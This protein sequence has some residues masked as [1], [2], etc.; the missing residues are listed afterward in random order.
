[1]Q[2]DNRRFYALIHYVHISIFTFPVLQRRLFMMRRLC[3]AVRLLSLFVLLLLCL[4]GCTKEDTQEETPVSLT[5]LQYELENQTID[6]S[7]MWFFD[8]LENKTGVHVD[9]EDVK[10]VD[11]KTRISLMFASNSYKDLILRGSLDT[12]EYGVTQGLLI[13]L[14]EYLEE[15]MPNYVSRLAL[16]HAG[17]AI[18]SSDGKSYYIGF[19]LAQNINTDG[20]FFINRTW[21]DKLGLET[22]TTIEELTDVLRAFRDQ[23]PN[24]NG[25]ADEVPYQATFDDNNAGIYNVFSAWGNPMNVDLAFTEAG[26]ASPRRSPASVKAWNGSTCSAR[27]GCWTWSASPRVP[28]CGWSR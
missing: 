14:D 8:Q 2:S 26:F 9:F 27:R 6:F 16:D 28:T 22:P 12:E 18:P 25:V 13:P 10:D 7:S 21:L 19:L 5:A 1:M 23:D 20:H 11:W 17:D 24:G 4:A 3:K 15:H